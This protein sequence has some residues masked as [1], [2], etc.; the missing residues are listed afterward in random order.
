[1][2]FT[3]TFF[4]HSM[5]RS[6]LG[7]IGPRLQVKGLAAGSLQLEQQTRK[8]RLRRLRPG[9]YWWMDDMDVNLACWLLDS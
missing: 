6:V 2:A 3:L 5:Y 4:A 9:R 7:S 8:T 1:M